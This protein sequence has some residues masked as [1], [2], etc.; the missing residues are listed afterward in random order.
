V[1]GTFTLTHDGQTTSSLGY[2]ATAAQVQSAL[3][4]LSTI[5]SGN[6]TVGKSVDTFDAQEWTLTFTGSLT[7]TNVV[8]TTVNSGSVSYYGMLTNTE[9][10]DTAGASDVDE[11]QTVTLSAAEG[12]QFRLAFAGET[13]K[14]LDYDAT[15]A[16]VESALEELNSVDNVSVSGNAGG[17]WTITFLGSNSGTDVDP[18]NGDASMVINGDLGNSFAFS[19]DAAHQLTSIADDYSSYAYTYDNLGR[20]LIVDNDG[21]PGV[22]NVI[23]TSAFNAGGHRTSLSAEI[24]S[25]DDFVNSYTYDALNRLTQL[26]Q[27]ATGSASVAEKRVDFSYNAIGQFTSIARFN[28]LDGGSGDEVATSTYSYDTLGRLTGLAYKNGGT[29]LFTP[30]EWSYDNLSS[31]GLGVSIS[32]DG[33]V[34][35]IAS[36]AAGSGLG[37]ITQFVSADGTSDYTYDATS[38]LTAAD[39]DYQTDEAYTYDANG[40]RTMT[41]Y[42]TGT[43]NRLT[44]DGTY[45]YTYDDEGNRITRTHDT[46]GEVTEYEW[47][48][49]NRLTKVTDKDEY[50]DV[51]QVVAY[52]YDV[53]NRRISRAVDT[54]SPFDL[55]DAVLERYVYDDNGMPPDPFALDT[56]N[57]NVVLDFL[58]P[59]GSGSQ[60]LTLNSRQLFG[61]AVDQILAQED[62][63]VTETSADRVLWPLVDNLATVR[64]LVKNDG[65]LGEHY[66][67]DSYGQIVSGDTSVTRYLYTSRE[68]DPDIGLQYNRARWYDTPTGRWISE[69][70]LGFSAGDAN[71]N[72]YVENSPVNYIDPTGLEK[73]IGELEEEIRQLQAERARAQHENKGQE[74]IREIDVELREKEKIKNKELDR[75]RANEQVKSRN[76]QFAEDQESD[77]RTIQKAQQKNRA[78]I[79]SIERTKLKADIALTEQARALNEANAKAV[80]QAQ[81]AHVKA[82][83]PRGTNLGAVGGLLGGLNVVHNILVFAAEVKEAKE[84]GSKNAFSDAWE[85]MWAEELNKTWVMPGMINPLPRTDSFGN[86]YRPI[87]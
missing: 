61:N 38:Q 28:D 27:G 6:V 71:P 42:T 25:T 35:A 34:A 24:D 33:R 17:P 56:S 10:T 29:N 31:A 49:R 75:R 22:A 85:N 45:S 74:I 79:E 39:H 68:Y 84:R 44:N 62:V 19:Y 60:P 20:V 69:D 83:A 9:V 82:K 13:T 30:Y 67:Y 72:R 73:N 59:D 70:P 11:V 32:A 63:T 8:Q 37:R 51:T 80:Q 36:A 16:Q 46:T 77:F 5:G 2:N 53:F 87:I 12:G 48:H 18:L 47:D 52:T 54:T 3:E 43:N 58:D 21:T 78:A 81:A 7:G 40:N 14:R 55:A 23:L 26:D 50:E 4:S 15:A 86:P 64:D 57:S 41:G 65:T 1:G 66:E 76:R